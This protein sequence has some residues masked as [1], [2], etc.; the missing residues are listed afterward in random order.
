MTEPLL[1]IDGDEI[2]WRVAAA[3][4][5]ETQWDEQNWV[6]WS[7]AEE[8]WQ[9][10][11]AAVARLFDRFGSQRH[12]LAFTGRNNFRKTIEPTYKANRTG[13]R[14]PMCYAVLR[15]RCLETFNCVSHEGLEA[16][17]VMGIL[18]TKPGAQRRIIC[19]QDKDF[20]SVPCEHWDGKD[21]VSYSSDE[22]DLAHL[23]QTLTGDAADGYKGCPGIG[24]AKAAKVLEKGPFWCEVVN[25]YRKAGLNEAEA[26]TQARL[27]RILRWTDW[28]S[29]NRKPILWTPPSST[30]SQN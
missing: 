23:M 3:L 27:A 18:A 24:P 4:E 13:K 9:E 29:E 14:K 12:A 10:A 28:D 1:L 5:K 17:D 22:A 25:A 6:L 15:E 26:L 8:V 7:N 2:I 21:L 11:T 20:K 30:G 19:G 16:D